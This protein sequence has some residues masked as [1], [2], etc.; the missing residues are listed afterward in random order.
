[1]HKTLF[2][3]LLLLLLLF[4]SLVFVQFGWWLDNLFFYELYHIFLLLVVVEEKVIAGKGITW[5]NANLHWDV[6][7]IIKFGLV[8]LVGIESFRWCYFRFNFPTFNNDQEE[9][10][11]LNCTAHYC[12]ETLHVHVKLFCFNLWLDFIYK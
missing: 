6:R 12:F 10:E 7:N 8:S 3:S 11:D 5:Y 9:N 2:T 1:M 4:F